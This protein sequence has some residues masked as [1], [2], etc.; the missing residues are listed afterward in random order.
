MLRFLVGLLFGFLLPQAVAEHMGLGYSF[1]DVFSV[2]PAAALDLALS[3]P[4]VS[5]AVARC[6]CLQGAWVGRRPFLHSDD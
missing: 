3:Q 6:R 1:S 4:W 5:P 2:V